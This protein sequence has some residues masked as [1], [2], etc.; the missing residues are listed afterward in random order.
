L[1]EIKRAP[2]I[3]AYISFRRFAVAAGAVA[4]AVILI[5]NAGAQVVTTVDGQPITEMDI[6]QRTRFHEMAT[7]KT[8]TRQNIID[9]LSNEIEQISLAERH[10][11]A[12]SEAEVNTTFEKIAKRMG[13]ETKKLTEILTDGGASRHFQAAA[14]GADCQEQA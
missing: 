3:P 6:E 10:A 5:S 13:I 1:W 4:I 9:E 2:Q 8:P 14:K 7:H 11:I 12:P